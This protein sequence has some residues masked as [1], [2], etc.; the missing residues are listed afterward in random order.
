MSFENF[1]CIIMSFKIKRHNITRV[2]SSWCVC[3]CACTKLTQGMDSAV[4][5][6]LLKPSGRLLEPS[7]LLLTPEA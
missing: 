4:R 3:V 1:I 5:C 6:W 7:G 2:I